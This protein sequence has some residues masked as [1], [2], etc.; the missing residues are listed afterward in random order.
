M[1]GFVKIEMLCAAK[2]I[3]VFQIVVYALKDIAVFRM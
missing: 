3:A 2:D 1:L